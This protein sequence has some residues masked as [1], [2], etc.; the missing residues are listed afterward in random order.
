MSIQIFM[1]QILALEIGQRLG[2]P[3]KNCAVVGEANL[4][5]NSMPMSERVNQ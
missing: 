4:I 5:E 3:Q 1:P 2:D